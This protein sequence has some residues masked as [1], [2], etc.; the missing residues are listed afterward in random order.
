M[1]VSEY[2]LEFLVRERLDELRRQA[3]TLRL[4]RTR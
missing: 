4:A 3:A 1:G 2:A